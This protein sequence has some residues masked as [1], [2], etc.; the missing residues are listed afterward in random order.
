[1]LSRT[2]STRFLLACMLALGVLLLLPPM[3]SALVPKDGGPAPGTE[4]RITTSP[5]DEYDPAISG[6]LIVYS[7]YRSTSTDVYYYNLA[8]GLETQVTNAVGDQELSDVNNGRIV[9]TDLETLDV[10][11]YDPATGS[12][13]NLTPDRPVSI[14]PCIS[15]DIVAWEDVDQG[16]QNI[17]ARDLA[18]NGLRQISLFSAPSG[19]PTDGVAGKPATDGKTIAWESFPWPE[20]TGS[21]LAYDWASGTTTTLAEDVGVDYRRPDVS[22]DKVVFDGGSGNDRDIYCYDLASNTMRRLELPG[23]QL[24]ANVSGDY[25][26]FEDL[27][28]GMYHLGIW[29][30]ATDTV[31]WVHANDAAGQ[32]L[33]DIDGHRLVYTDDPGGQLDIYMRT[34]D[35]RPPTLTVTSPVQGAVYTKYDTP[36]AQWSAVDDY[37]GVAS[38][39]DIASGQALP[40]T[41]GTHTVTFW[42]TDG[43]GNR[44]SIDRT[45]TVQNVGLS[46]FPAPGATL[47]FGDVT[48]GQA[49]T[50]IVTATNSGQAPLWISAATT[51][52]TP[53]AFSVSGGGVLL[54]PGQAVDLA[55][56]FAPTTTAVLSGALHVEGC[57][58][59][60]HAAYPLGLADI[61]LTGRG[62]SAELPPNQAAQKLLV[63]YNA[64]IANGTLWGSGSGVCAA[65]RVKA[66]RCMIEATGDYIARGNKIM[67]RILLNLVIDCCDGQPPDFVSGPARQPICDEAKALLKSIGG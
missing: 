48:V 18:N 49:V 36:V 26:C 15:G 22:G 17:W 20:M 58:A 14:N 11:L 59:T 30:L 45:Y 10:M 52:T 43:F 33:N 21:I 32:Y 28:S 13:T 12:S 55:V 53:A 65:L 56:R 46:L 5:G 31:Y 35:V 29:D 7:S 37:S 42:A 39:G 23:N 16:I 50:Q 61:V 54:N 47:P 63:D 44:A 41:P 60:S 38:S 3:A 6:N 4:T 2:L 57:D 34:F 25:V 64:A 24:D 67:A 19:G 1:M 51:S 62:V 8:T 9:Y 40:M 27:S 66:M